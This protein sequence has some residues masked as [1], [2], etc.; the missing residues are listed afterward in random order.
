MACQ[1]KRITRRIGHMSKNEIDARIK[2][3]A[4]L[5][6]SLIKLDRLLFL[7]K[8]QKRLFK[9]IVALSNQKPVSIQ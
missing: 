4:K 9:G 3:E 8:E 1:T 2:Y 5:G 7:S 6:V